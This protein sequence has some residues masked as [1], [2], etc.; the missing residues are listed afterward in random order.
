MTNHT[1]MML[2]SQALFQFLPVVVFSFCDTNVHLLLL[3]VNRCN[4]NII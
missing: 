4:F 1:L 3:T 2:N